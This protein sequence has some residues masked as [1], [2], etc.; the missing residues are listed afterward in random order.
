MSQRIDPVY[1][2][3]IIC[4]SGDGQ[5]A[6]DWHATITRRSDGK[7]AVEVA[8]MAWLILYPTRRKALD[9]TFRW[10]DKRDQ[11]MVEVKELQR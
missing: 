9:R 10:I 8:S 2:V 5:V 1:D 11:K 3:K 6:D 7:R 4:R